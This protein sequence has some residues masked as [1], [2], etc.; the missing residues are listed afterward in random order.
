MSNSPPEASVT[1][2]EII[3]RLTQA[4]TDLLWSSESDYPFEIV[5]WAQATEIIPT[6]LFSNLDEDES[7][8]ESTTITDLFAPVI[9]VEDWY[10]QTELAIV[11]RYKSLLATIE[12]NLLEVQV[13][14]IGEIETAIYIVGKTPAGD[15]IGLKTYSIET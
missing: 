15:I 11:D 4:T 9:T 7:L 13:F 5:T 14:R 12:T 8:I 10:K 2:A 1:T 6:A 3:D